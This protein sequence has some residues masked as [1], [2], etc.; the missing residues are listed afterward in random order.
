MTVSNTQVICP[1]CHTVLKPAKPLPVGKKV[2]CP[3]CGLT[4]AAPGSDPDV[5]AKPKAGGA[6]AA[7]KPAAKKPVAKKGADGRGDKAV[8]KAPPGK[9]AAKKPADEED[10]GGATYGVVQEKAPEEDEEDKPDIDYAPDM[11][12]KDL[13]GPAQAEVM[14][15]SNWMIFKGALGFLG[16]LA[17][18]VVV[19]IPVL[20][21]LDYDDKDKGKDKGGAA[22]AAP[23]PAA[24]GAPAKKE[25]APNRS[26]FQLGSYD[27]RDLAKYS[28]IMIVVMLLPLLVL[29]VYSALIAVGAV[30]MQ[31][32]ESRGWAI[33][34]SIMLMLPLNAGG[35]MLLSAL[36]EQ[37]LLL[38]VLDY[39]WF[40]IM[41]MLITV[42]IEWL[43]QVG[44]GIWNLTVLMKPEVIAG[45]EY[46][47]E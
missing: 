46:K 17:F 47:P 7:N 6:A 34:S 45:F 15:P 36:T 39:D 14:K 40:V 5:L 38:V 22:P 35:V 44:I 1:E 27:L 37:F 21:P 41:L 23:A 11:S 42:G 12:I 4:F 43:L 25:D 33:A 10:E 31:N 18:L 26:F 28:K 19:L 16:W 2:K 29:M 24:P 3:K 9:P 8:K 32:L 20:F 30:H 13:R